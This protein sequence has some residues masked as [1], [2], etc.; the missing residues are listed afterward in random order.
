[1]RSYLDLCLVLW[2]K[3]S[4]SSNFREIIGSAR[5]KEVSLLESLEPTFVLVYL[6]E[7]LDF[8]TPTSLFFP[9]YLEFQKI[10][11]KSGD[12]VKNVRTKFT[13]QA[14][15]LPIANT[16][17]CLINIFCLKIHSSYGGLEARLWR[18]PLTNTFSPTIAYWVAC[19][20]ARWFTQK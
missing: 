17:L 4:E 14:G 2:L 11:R 9:L 10:C 5:T 15:T 13:K 1:M 8:R 18:A 7:E 3:C 6:L 19:W 12:Y 16:K 20:V